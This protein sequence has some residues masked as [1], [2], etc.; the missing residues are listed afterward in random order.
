MKIIHLLPALTKGGAESMVV[1]LANQ[2]AAAGH[3]VTV[4][5]AFPVDPT[6]NQDKL[7]AAVAVQLI[8]PPGRGVATRYLAL[9]PWLWRNRRFL[10]Q[11]DVVHCHLTFATLAGSLLQIARWLAGAK[12]PRVV[13]TFHAAGM[14]LPKWKRRLFHLSARMRDGF[15][16]MAPEAPG[17]VF[18]AETNPAIT[19]VANGINLDMKHPGPAAA[20]DYRRVVGIPEGARVVGTV[21]RI[22]P[23]RAPLS[24]VATCSEIARIAPSDIHFFMGGEGSLRDQ[25]LAEAERLGIADRLHL[26][27]LVRDPATAFT[28]M[29]VYLTINVGELTGVAGL[30]AAAFGLPVI[31]VNTRADHDGS[32]DWIWSHSDPAV[33]A[34]RAAELLANESSR[35]ALVAQQQRHVRENFSGEAMW[36]AYEAFYLAAGVA[37]LSSARTCS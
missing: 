3:D 5:I 14:P 15:A 30:E 16:V 36:R 22:V 34:Q 1:E 37:E 7:N 31:A 11:Q 18:S 2:A 27:G 25:V 20:Q 8:N 29:D 35:S 26:P 32:N 28:L 21:G 19:L 12:K 33:V 4:V 13:E 9:L 17:S 24:I 23:D 10:S 6:L